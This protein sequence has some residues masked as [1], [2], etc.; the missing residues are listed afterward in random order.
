MRRMIKK[1]QMLIKRYLMAGKRIKTLLISEIEEISWVG[2][3]DVREMNC[4]LR[5]KHI[6]IEERRVEVN[7]NSKVLE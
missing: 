4:L 5:H 6:F 2:H 3:G 7:Y 1:L